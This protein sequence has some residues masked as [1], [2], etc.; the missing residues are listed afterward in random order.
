M[1]YQSNE[2]RKKYLDFFK[3]KNHV[4]IP[5]A[6][7]VP[8][9]D[10]TVL[11]NTAGMQ[12]LVPYLLGESHPL[13][14]RL[15]DSQKCIRTGDIEEVGDDSHLTF[16]EM[17][18]NWSLGDYF[19]E[20]SINWSYEFLTSPDG[21]ALDPRKIA[22]TVFKGD[23]D[24]PKDE[25]SASVWES[26]GI[27]KN[28]ISYLGKDDNWWAAGSTGPCGPDSE[29]F[30]WV[31]KS[32]FPPEESN[33]GNDENNWMEIWNNVFME[34]NRLPDG[35]LE[36]LPNQNVDT[37]MGL[38]RITAT[39][40]GV[41]SVYETD[42]F[43]EIIA[44]ICKVL[45][46]EY[47]EQN[48]K[49]IR[50]IADH[51]RTA[52][53]IISDGVVPSNVDQGY[54]LRRLIRIAVRQAQKLGFKG[55]FLY[56][57]ADKVIDK[58]GG[59]YPHMIEK[60]EQIKAEIQKEEKQFGQTLEKGLKEFEKLVK[61]FEIAFEKTGKKIEIISGDKAFKLYDTYGFPL[62]MT[63]DLALEHG[64]KVDEEGFHKA[65]AEHQAKSR[66][67]AE[68]KFKGGLADTGK[69]TVALHS[70][71]HLL[72]AGLRKFVGPHVHQKGSN[73]T[74][75]RLRF[76]FNNDEKL[77]PEILA[78]VEDYVNGAISA[79]F[80]VSVEQIPKQ[81][82]KDKGVEGSFWE[83]YPDIVKVYT[84][85]GNDGTIYSRELCGGPHVQDSTGM[86][87]FKIKKE[88]SSSA[89]VRRIKAILEK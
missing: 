63:K 59:A 77:T 5:S 70:A 83:K 67:G 27:P 46:V 36:K 12:P 69:E 30:Y 55:E 50:I 80:T 23:A 53:V 16:F 56:K 65:E 87:K 51:S 29:I 15:T 18:G 84:M 25:F 3:S 76:D 49:S 82:A 64:L 1:K 20:D 58:L 6:P 19:K 44:E 86:G 24:A 4:V 48:K 45:G 71:T 61:G 31:G 41:K 9:N 74:P 78:Q 89:G 14:K 34:Y 26:V 2:L 22:V 38:E 37:G 13:G 62:E 47:N 68:K 73:I 11:F 17:L 88:E 52:S 66:V 40:N 33:V 21:L 43:A 57:I 8:D 28:K 79:G 10:P 32:E 42:I 85:T 54:V 60:R 35:K 81:E 7:V 39:L 72:L 75:E